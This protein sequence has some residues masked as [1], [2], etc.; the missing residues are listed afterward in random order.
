MRHLGASTSAIIGTTIIMA[1]VYKK[2][3]PD[4]TEIS[5]GTFIPFFPQ[6]SRSNKL[7]KLHLKSDCSL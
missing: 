1:I 4:N 2:G 7:I 6:P 5:T 3:S